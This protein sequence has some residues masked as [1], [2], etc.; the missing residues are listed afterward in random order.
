MD[1]TIDLNMRQ[2][3]AVAAILNCKTIKEAAIQIDVSERS[4][5]RWLQ[6]EGFKFELRQARREI[7]RQ[8]TTRLQQIAGEAVETLHDAMKNHEK[9]TSASRVSA[10]RSALDYAYRAVELE[11]LDERVATLEQTNQQHH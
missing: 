3:R 11:D 4:L 9:A 8:A 2:D 1:N 5:Y 10:A 7:L 6:D